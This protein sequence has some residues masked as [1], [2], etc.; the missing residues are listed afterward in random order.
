M[1]EAATKLKESV[2]A[3]KKWQAAIKAAAARRKREAEAA[4]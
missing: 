4:K 3:L 1:S 2:S